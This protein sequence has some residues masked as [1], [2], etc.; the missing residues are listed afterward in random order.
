MTDRRPDQQEMSKSK[1]ARTDNLDPKENPYLAHFYE[2]E[3]DNSYSRNGYSN[4]SSGRTG[5]SDFKRHETTAAQAHKA[6]DGPN[7]P[8]NNSPLSPRYFD[9]LKTRRDL[10]VHKQRYVA[11]YL[12]TC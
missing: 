4:S 5:L 6:E 7:N 2:V 12:K 8:F 3:E 1:R 10:P 11:L 9:I